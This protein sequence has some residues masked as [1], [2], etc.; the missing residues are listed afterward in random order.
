MLLEKKKLISIWILLTV[1]IC[2]MLIY[3]FAKAEPPKMPIP[4]GTLDLSQWD[5]DSTLSLSGNWEF[6]WNQFLDKNDLK[7]HPTPDLKA[8]V[9]SVWNDFIVDG[10]KIGGMGYA[11]YHLH[12][13]GAKADT[14]LAMRI[15]PFSTAYALY[16]D[17]ALVAS[18]G[19]V[20]TSKNGFLP[21][22]EVQTVSF[23]PKQENFDII[24]HISNFVYAR[25]GAW[26]TI[27]FGNPEKI[28]H[29]SQMIFGMDFFITGCL[30][31]LFFFSMFL[32]SLRHDKGYFLFL[33]LCIA[34]IG[35]TCI[36][37]N[38]LINILFSS[39]RFLAVVLID[40]ITLYWL[41]C[42]CLGL[43]K[44]MYPK[45]ISGK[46]IDFLIV[47]GIG[48]TILTLLSPV[49]A[50]TNFIYFADAI[51]FGSGIYGIVKTIQITVKGEP[52]V[53]FIV[54][55]E[56]ALILCISYDVLYET[57]MIN[58]GFKEFSPFGFLITAALLQ[59]MFWV[60]YDRNCREK[61]RVLLE[62]NEAD[63]REQKLEL[64]FLKSQI[65]P[66][67]INNALNAIISISRTDPDKARKLLTEFSKYLRNCYSAK[68]PENLVPI[69]NELSFVRAYVALEQARFSD[70]LHIEYDIDSIFLLIP[71]LT[72]QPL[73]ENAIIHGVME[74]SEDGHILIYVKDCGNFVKVGVTD[75]GVGIPP[76]LISTLLSNEHHGNGVGI[77]NINR[78]MK[79]LFS[80][81]LHII[82]RPEG[83][84]DAYIIIPKE[85]ELCCEPY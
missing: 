28:F 22:Y 33:A 60:R 73:V 40:Y 83:G 48:M 52:E 78:R 53:F 14:P 25:G 50:F 18:S 2:G 1:I 7:N 26:Y 46:L 57:N 82:S 67:F 71:P 81:K 32:F 5:G 12:I 19:Q 29:I 68:D 62:L 69:E 77:Y 27:Y 30:M 85:E 8:K 13:T 31:L 17:D 6:Y 75:D 84:T 42:L 16:V 23:V 24:L 37:G 35:R 38:Y 51:A 49:K 44:Y 36:N 20:S 3:L 10:K 9:P 65:R 59:C 70:F 45:D 72:L 55:G 4:N 21:Q 74:K 58:N 11:T 43:L 63:K 41:P 39:P 66:H 15:V 79:K 64:E 47:Y 34:F 54:A 76:E 61:E 80:T 56:S